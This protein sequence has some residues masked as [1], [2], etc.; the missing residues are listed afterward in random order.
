MKKLGKKLMAV[1]GVIVMIVIFLVFGFA[2]TRIPGV[3][4]LAMWGLCTAAICYGTGTRL[5]I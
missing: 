1:T 4:Y 5:A 3:A 2:E